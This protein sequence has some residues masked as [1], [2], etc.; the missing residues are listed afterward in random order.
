MFL[1]FFQ[2]FIKTL[3]SEPKL[4]IKTTIQKIIVYRP[5]RNSL[6][7]KDDWCSFFKVECLNV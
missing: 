3:F 5:T 4:Q 1:I 6:E 2:V 7:R